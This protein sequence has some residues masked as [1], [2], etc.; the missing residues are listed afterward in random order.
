MVPPPVPNASGER[1]DLVVGKVAGGGHHDVRGLVVGLPELA[2]GRRRERSHALL[3]PGDLAAQ[4]RVVEDREIEENVH[5]L[6]RVVEV[7]ADLLDDDIPLVLDLRL[8]EVGPDDE[9]AQHLHRGCGV[10]RRDADVVDGRFAIRRCVEG[11]AEALHRLGECA[12]RR[13]GPRSLERQ[14]LHEMRATGLPGCLVARARQDV[15]LHRERA[16]AR[17]TRSDDAWPVGQRRSFEHRGRVAETKPCRT[18]ATHRP[19]R[20]GLSFG[21]ARTR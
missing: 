21:C 12:R 17:Q 16:G 19:G 10:A 15:R 18:P 7:R 11:A 14:V 5:V 9:L 1:H 8:V 13:I 4:R 6:G 3:R 20:G 2:D